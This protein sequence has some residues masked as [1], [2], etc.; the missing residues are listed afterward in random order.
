MGHGTRMALIGRCWGTDALPGTWRKVCGGPGR[1][2][3]EGFPE[4]FRCRW[5]T[6][7]NTARGTSAPAGDRG[8]QV[9]FREG[10]RWCRVDTAGGTRGLAGDRGGR[11]GLRVG[12]GPRD[13]PLLALAHAAVP[14]AAHAVIRPEGAVAVQVHL[15]VPEKGLLYKLPQQRT[16]LQGIELLHGAIVATCAPTALFFSS[17]SFLFVCFSFLFPHPD[18]QIQ[19]HSGPAHMDTCIH[20]LCNMFCAPERFV[21]VVSWLEAKHCARPLNLYKRRCYG[22]VRCGTTDP[23]V[24]WFGA[25]WHS[26]PRHAACWLRVI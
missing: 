3:G 15:E 12:P 13:L 7:G 19:D 14:Q 20:V 8:G 24:S 18:D 6:R 23:N 22:V 4:G 9:E 16:Q 10:L 17:C 1:G 25:W 11:V 2:C 26:Y 5:D 21:R